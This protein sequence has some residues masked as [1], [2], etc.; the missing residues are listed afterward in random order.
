MLSA[1]HVAQHHSSRNKLRSTKLY[2]TLRPGVKMLQT[3]NIRVAFNDVLLL[4]NA[5]AFA[6]LGA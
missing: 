6:K 4:L 1:S 5:K 3:F 2:G